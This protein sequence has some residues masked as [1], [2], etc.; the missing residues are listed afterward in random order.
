MISN[1]PCV[2]E[3]ETVGSNLASKA[4]DMTVDEFRELIK[5]DFRFADATRPLLAEEW[6]YQRGFLNIADYSPAGY[7]R[8]GVSVKRGILADLTGFGRHQRDVRHQAVA[9]LNQL[10]ET[11]PNETAGPEYGILGKETNAHVLRLLAEDKPLERIF[12]DYMTQ[13]NWW[14]KYD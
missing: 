9:T 13:N 14:C 10:V 4:R 3:S 12:K 1:G 2:I 5:E 7:L 11:A 6:L 8:Q